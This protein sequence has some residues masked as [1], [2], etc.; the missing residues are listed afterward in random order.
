M[1]NIFQQLNNLTIIPKIQIPDMLKSKREVNFL[2]KFK[3]E[4][5]EAIIPVINYTRIDKAIIYVL[6]RIFFYIFQEPK[7]FSRI[8]L[9]FLL[10]QRPSV[11]FVRC[12][13]NFCE[14]CHVKRNCWSTDYSMENLL[15]LQN[16]KWN[17]II[18][19]FNIKDKKIY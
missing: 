4:P 8:C 17:L 9:A 18:I 1:R 2:K 14:Q 6:N 19:S 7:I 13:Q 12:E 5:I 15:P 10:Y 11:I 3:L 16:P